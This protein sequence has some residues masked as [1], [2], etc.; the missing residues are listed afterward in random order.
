MQWAESKMIGGVSE[1]TLLTPIKPG[2]IDGQ[3]QTYEERLSGELDSVQQRVEQRIP[4][5][6]GMLPTIHFARWII[7]RPRQY[8][9]YSGKTPE[10]P[11]LLRGAATLPQRPRGGDGAPAKEETRREA[12]PKTAP[13]SGEAASSTGKQYRGG[14]G[15]EGYRS[16]LLFT[17]NFDGDMKAYLRDFAVFLGDDVDRIWGNC[18]NWPA[19]GCRA[20]EEYWDYAK[21]YQIPT[22]AFY[23]AYPDLSVGRIRQ[24]ERFKSAFDEFVATTRQPDGSS[25]ADLAARFDEFL[26]QNAQYPTDFPRLGGT[27][28]GLQD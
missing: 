23:A 19:G 27:F 14:S 4:T 17:S 15:P 16:W 2:P 28:A 21:R 8:L 13:P 1:V 9:Q 26:S 7:L 24:L 10:E 5:P 6:V 20:F 25:I 22:N 12:P 3:A 11:Q 18:E